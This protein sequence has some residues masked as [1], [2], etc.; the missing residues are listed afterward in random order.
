MK[1]ALHTT[2]IMLVLAVIS[3][4]AAMYY[5]PWPEFAVVD[6]E[7]GKPLFAEYSADSVRGIDIIDFNSEKGALDRMTLIRRGQKWLIPEKQNFI[8]SESRRVGVVINSLNERTVFDVISENQEDHIEYGVVDPI[9]YSNQNPNSLGKKLT[10]TDRNNQKIADL[11][12]GSALK[13]DPK[14]RY[15]RIPGKPRVYTIEFDSRALATDFALWNSANALRLQIQAEGQGRQIRQI[16]INNYK[17]NSQETESKLSLIYN[18][19]LGP[20]EGRLAVKSLVVPRGG[21]LT[22]AA[23]TPAIDAKLSATL[24]PLAFFF[25]DDVR[26]KSQAVAEAMMKPSSQTPTESLSE[27]SNYGFYVKGFRNDQWDIASDN[28]QIRI[29][30]NEGVITTVSIGSVGSPNSA[31]K[32]KLNYFVMLNSGIDSKFLQKPVRPPGVEEDESDENRAYLRAV[33]AWEKA[34]SNAKQIAQELNVIHGDWYYLVSEDI[35][36]TIRPDLP[37]PGAPASSATAQEKAPSDGVGKTPAETDANSDTNEAAESDA[38][39]EPSASDQS[40]ATKEAAESSESAE[41]DSEKQT[42][43]AGKL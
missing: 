6:A 33:A 23:T 22:K 16:E 41:T 37:I 30:T 34:M 38:N 36:K 32:S 12:V 17:I 11:I 3:V 35:I 5:F 9:E 8:A 31:G 26:R 10:I 1:S 28:G 25:T 29:A 39:A 42:S 21:Q 4:G 40:E 27:M 13:D 14:K 2:L 43:D 19:V 24:Q 7:V 20:Q 15:V 18:A